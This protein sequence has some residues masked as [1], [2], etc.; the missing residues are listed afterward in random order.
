[1]AI[2]QTN[3]LLRNKIAEIVA[4]N[5]DIK[6]SLITISYVD[7][8]PN[9]Q[10]AKVAFSVIPDNHVGSSLEKLR[11]ASGLI[12]NELRKQTRLRKIPKLT[13]KFDER[14]K[15]VSALDEIFNQIEKE[16]EEDE[17]EKEAKNNLE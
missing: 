11:K 1:M 2:E 13:W 4:R 14:G 7:C 6:N 9:M 12:T 17:K 3:E 15:H 8:A 10:S 16:R 5:V